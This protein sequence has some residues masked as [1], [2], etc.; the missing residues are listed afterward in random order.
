MDDKDGRVWAEK[1]VGIG[2]IS[3]EGG[4]G[5]D[6][7]SQDDGGLERRLDKATA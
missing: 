7:D 5:P 6:N 1:Q 2:A 3:L 4:F